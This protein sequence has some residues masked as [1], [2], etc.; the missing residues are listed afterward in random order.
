MCREDLRRANELRAKF[1]DALMTEREEQTSAVEKE[2]AYRR[3]LQ[4]QILERANKRRRPDQTK[5]VWR[6]VLCCGC[7]GAPV[8]LF[9]V[10]QPAH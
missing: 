8:A 9:Q 2:L 7:R 1:Q 10:M 6:P 5:C 3:E 4:E